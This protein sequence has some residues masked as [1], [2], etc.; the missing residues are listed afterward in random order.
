[1]TPPRDETGTETQVAHLLDV[2]S[3]HRDERCAKLREQACAQAKTLLLQAHL[4]SRARMHEHI[5]AMREKQRQRIAAACARNE[6]LARLQQQQ[7]GQVMLN[8]AWQPLHDAL[9]QRWQQESTRRPWIDALLDVAARALLA[10][11]WRIEHPTDWPRAEH[12]DL[13]HRLIPL[14]VSAPVFVAYEDIVAGLRIVA[15]GATIDATLIGLLQRKTA[16]EAVLMARLMP[17]VANGHL[18]GAA[19]EL[20]V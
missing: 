7:V 16:I 10:H 19:T 20:H 14:G 2:V 8:R 1:M 18:R 5:V 17:L 4:K 12:E 11:D 13:Q 15:P 3:R 6:T 9:K